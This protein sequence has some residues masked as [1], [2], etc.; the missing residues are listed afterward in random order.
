[1]KIS[2]VFEKANMKYL[3]NEYLPIAER[4]ITPEYKSED[5]FTLLLRVVDFFYNKEKNLSQ[6]IWETL[7]TRFGGMVLEPLC[8]LYLF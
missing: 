7:K 2:F 8:F 5:D 6:D 1:M 3:P 4:Q